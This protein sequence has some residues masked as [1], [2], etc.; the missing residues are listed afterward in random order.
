MVLRKLLSW[1]A[2]VCSGSTNEARIQAAETL[3][4]MLRRTP[5]PSIAEFYRAANEA[6]ALRV[7]EDIV[8]PLL[9]Q[10]VL[11]EAALREAEHERFAE[12]IQRLVG[13]LQARDADLQARDADLQALREQL[14]A[15]LARRSRRKRAESPRRLVAH[16]MLER[17]A[18]AQVAR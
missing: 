14:A 10:F 9:E 12:E 6:L 4:L 17:R 2:G 1:L 5:R 11:E 7:P 15:V 8:N 13:N 18:V 3:R 16:R